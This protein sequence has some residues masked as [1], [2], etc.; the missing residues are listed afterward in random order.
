MTKIPVP[1][2]HVWLPLV[3]AEASSATRIILSGY[4]MK[5][6]VLGLVRFGASV[7]NSN[8]VMSLL[9]FVCTFGLLFILSSYRECDA[10]R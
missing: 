10:K 3:H 7:L 1:P 6:G 4:I 8:S 5:L 2:F 9:L